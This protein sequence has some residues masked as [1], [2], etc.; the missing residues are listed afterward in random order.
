MLRSN[1]MYQ[2]KG[3]TRRKISMYGEEMIKFVRPFEIIKYIILNLHSLKYNYEK[4]KDSCRVD[5]FL[6]LDHSKCKIKE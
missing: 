5:Y 6:F 1:Y 2:Y 3:K 4:S